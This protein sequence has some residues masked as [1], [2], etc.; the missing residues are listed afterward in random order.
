MIVSRI[1]MTRPRVMSLYLLIMAATMSVPPALP[2]DEK[3]IPSPVP[4]MEAPK[5]QAMKG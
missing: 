1:I 5:T 3:A 2:L 4:Q